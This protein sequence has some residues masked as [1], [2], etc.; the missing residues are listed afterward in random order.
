[1]WS[2]QR[3]QILEKSVHPKNNNSVISSVIIVIYYDKLNYPSVHQRSNSIEC[4]RHALL[5]TKKR[6]WNE[7]RKNK[8]FYSS[9]K[10]K[11]SLKLPMVCM[12]NKHTFLV[13]CNKR[14]VMCLCN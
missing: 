11:N 12:T 10:K 2:T 9:L 6:I 1:M 5:L 14:T 4:F 7:K 13:F 8:I 3:I